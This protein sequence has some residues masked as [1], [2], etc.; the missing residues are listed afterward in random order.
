MADI[1]TNRE[2]ERQWSDLVTRI[3]S[4]ATPFPRDSTEKKM[5]RQKRSA[6]D[7]FF[8]AA[9]YFPHYIQ[10]NE[11]YLRRALKQPKGPLYIDPDA[12]VDWIKAGFADIHPEFWK[13][14]GVQNKF[15]IL[16]AFRESAKDTL[17]GKIDAIHKLTAPIAKGGCWFIATI[18]FSEPHAATKVMPIRIE[19]ESNE[20]LLNDF[21]PMQSS[22][23]W[24]QGSIITANGRKMTGFGRD[25]TLRGQEHVGHRPDWFLPNDVSDPTKLT[26]PSIILKYVESMKQDVLK[27]ANSPRW[28]GI[29][30]CNY[31]SKQSIEHELLTGEH[32]QHYG[33]H[34]IRALVPNE[35]RTEEERQI[36]HDCRMMKFPDSMR[37]AWEFRHPTIRLLEEQRNDPDTF[38][39]EMMMRPGDRKNKK[40]K[41]ADFKFYTESQI[42]GREMIY[43]SMIDPSAKEAS[44]YKALVE[45]GVP[46][47]GETLEMFVTHAWIQQTSVDAML[48]ETWRANEIHR[49]KMIGVEMIAFA[50]LLEREYAR[51]MKKK[52]TP[53]PIYKIEHVD[54]KDAVIESLVP[55]VRS[56]ILK[57][58]PQQGDQGLLIRQLKAFPDRT[59]VSRGGIGDDGPDALGKCIRLVQDFPHGRALR[60]DSVRKRDA[61]FQPGAY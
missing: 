30:L 29:F 21:G 37:S 57:F 59:Q 6:V 22:I 56:G 19:F 33:K 27:S 46:I 55:Y 26:N 58:N 40:F 4:Q 47:E 18:A 48:E 54:P 32:T 24:E 14:T 12:E 25:Q 17:I 42:A 38:D 36:A 53:L 23:Q 15:E 35:K 13:L 31:V 49:Q 28:G 39:R 11:E 10:V 44:D 43:W 9:T 50:V 34:I 61:V 60:Y 1:T 51:L 8:F 45:V 3:K 5:A 52:G 16:A 20:R 7:K 41:D 2:F